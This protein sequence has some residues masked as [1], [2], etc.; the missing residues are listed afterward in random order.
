M[1]QRA[2]ETRPDGGAGE[3]TERPA[4]FNERWQDP[5]ALYRSLPTMARD[6]WWMNTALMHVPQAGVE[7]NGSL[8]FNANTTSGS[9]ENKPLKFDPKA[10]PQEQLTAF[11]A[12]YERAEKDSNGRAKI[13][14]GEGENA[15]EVL[16][17]RQ[18]M[19][20]ANLLHVLGTDGHV[21]MRAVE[22]EGNWEQQRDKRGNQVSWF[23]KRYSGEQGDNSGTR[24]GP[25]V[26]PP[27]GSDRE[28]P[29]QGDRRPNGDRTNPNG[30]RPNPN[31]DRSVQP[32]SSDQGPVVRQWDNVRL[33]AYFSGRGAGRGEGGPKDQRGRPL[34]TVEE[35]LQDPS[36]PVSVA[37]DLN[38]YR[39][40]RIQ[41][42]QPVS[43]PEMDRKY[44]AELNRL[45]QEGKLS[46][47]RF[48]FVAVDNG[49]AVR[50][51]NHMDIA[52]A[53]YKSRRFPDVDLHGRANVSFH[54]PRRR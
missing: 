30:D 5:T 11:A 27:E 25:L 44:A 28:R 38:H 14:I 20:K 1:T 49:P 17:E 9:A 4:T 8:W 37:V 51:E 10:P 53:R 42:G 21:M 50:G 47:P 19:G 45:V 40:G 46:E 52:L 29:P 22:R 23:G 3:V 43:I 2:E 13:K 31:G 54:S 7:Q 24:P 26:G 34:Y 18:Q 35:F 33:T 41:Y 48:R 36:K 6:Q 16:V 12:A 32:S 15:R 39:S